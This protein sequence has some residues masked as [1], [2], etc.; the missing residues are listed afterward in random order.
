M[1]LRLKSI[2]KMTV[3]ESIMTAKKKWDM[4]VHKVDDAITR[5]NSVTTSQDSELAGH[6][7]EAIEKAY[8]K[9]EESWDVLINQILEAG[10]D[11][12]KFLSAHEQVVERKWDMI[13]RLTSMRKK[14]REEENKPKPKKRCTCIEDPRIPR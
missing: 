11:D 12:K 5:A 1:P 2:L 10:I 14:L 6:H 7:I 4:R 13:G 3:P 9:Y 8:S